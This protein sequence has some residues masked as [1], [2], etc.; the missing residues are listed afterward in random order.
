MRSD[1]KPKQGPTEETFEVGLAHKRKPKPVRSG[2]LIEYAGWIVGAA[3]LL[4]FLVPFGILK[5]HRSSSD[6][7]PNINA[8]RLEVVFGPIKIY[9]EG[10]DYQL[11]EV[12]VKIGNQGATTASGV[13]VLAVTPSKA[14]PLVGSKTIEPGK[15]EMYKGSLEDKLSTGQDRVIKFTCANC[16]G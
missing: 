7:V 10:S 11:R 3:I 13:Q 14:T 12:Q 5:L 2:W 16:E 1:D 6:G 9:A 8:P 15:A 4:L